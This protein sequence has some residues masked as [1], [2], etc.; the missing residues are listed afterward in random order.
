MEPEEEEERY[1]APAS[2]QSPVHSPAA[3]IA[4]I[5]N[6]QIAAAPPTRHIQYTP[7]ASDEEE[8][9]SPALPA[10]PASIVV[11]SVSSP[12]SPSG[13][14]ESPP[15]N[16]VQRRDTVNHSD[17]PRHPPASFHMY[18]VNEMVSVMGKKK[19]MPTTLGINNAT[20]VIL[21]APE[22][23]RDGPEQTWS[24]EKMTHYSIEGKHVFLELVRPSKSID[25]H[26][27]AKD[28]AE[29]IVSAL[30]ELAG[31]VRAEGLREVYMAG[32]GHEQKKGLVMYD[33]TAHGEDEVSVKVGDEVL[34]IDDQKSEEW[35]QVRRLKNGKDGVV[36]SSYI[37]VTGTVPS[38]QSQIS[39]AEQARIDEERMAKDA[40][41]AARRAELGGGSEVG[42]GILLPE[43]GSSLATQDNNDS[44]QQHRKRDS[45]RQDSQHSSNKSTKSS[46]FFFAV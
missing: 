4:G 43:R 11:P 10:R 2:P 9:P 5:L 25:F 18:N 12:R 34:I 37:E 27:G 44:E 40:V 30:G 35:W 19:K 17:G 24:A 1:Q 39:S 45:S 3:D 7:E 41:N 8:P 33:F 29:E 36:P 31:A 20:G 14:I 6:R 42:P 32:S 22:K 28:T 13:P 16:R 23:S 15:Y 46:K 21:I 26:A 38:A